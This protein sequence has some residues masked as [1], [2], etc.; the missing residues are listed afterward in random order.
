MRI[1][2]Y[3]FCCLLALGSASR[4]EIAVKIAYLEH[5]LDPPPTLS[6]LDP[7]PLDEGLRG[8]ELGI[9][10][11]ATT[12]RFMGHAYELAAFVVDEGGDFGA[13]AMEAVAAAD[14]LVVKAPADELLDLADMA[15]TKG[16]LIFNAGA[17]ETALRDADCRANIL[18]TLPSRAMLADSL[19]QFAVAKR[20]TDW[21]LIAGPKPGDLALANAFEASAAKFGVRIGGR[22]AWTF[23]ADMRRNAGAEVPLFTQDLPEHDLLVVADE[24]NDFA[25]YVLYNTWEPRPVAGSEGIVPAAWHASVEQ[26]GAAQL[27][28]RFRD[29]A[30][31]DMRP[32]DWAAWAA[33]RSIGEA[34]TRTGSADADTV[35]TFLLS[36]AFE[37]GGFKGRKLSYR[38]WNGQLRQPIPLAHPSAVVALA[39]MEGFLHQV[40]ELDT[41]GIDAAE[42]ACTAMGGE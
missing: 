6:N 29:L 1:L 14:F 12:G 9:A 33:V 36:E 38:R 28:S 32:I 3:T 8:A 18:H 22:K 42:S 15:A 5:R 26:H 11:S 7:V 31:R 21:A 2:V 40:N 10:D 23:D 4:A 37:L 35:R 30:G 19:A 27:Q 17:P 34:V 24:A 13:A 25:R 20:W 41:L 16:K 39:P